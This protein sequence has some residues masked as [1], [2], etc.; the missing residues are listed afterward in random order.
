MHR[1][2]FEPRISHTKIV[3]A[4]HYT[5]KA[6]LL[7]SILEF[8]DMMVSQVQPTSVMERSIQVQK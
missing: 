5:M 2:G 3:D 4:N 8:I 7:H 1:P 6:G